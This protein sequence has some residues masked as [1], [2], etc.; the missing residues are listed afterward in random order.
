LAKS[1]QAAAGGDQQVIGVAVV[2]AIEL[3]HDISSGG[4]ARQAQRAHA[5]FRP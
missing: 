4:G 2:A 3:D 5:R 1:R